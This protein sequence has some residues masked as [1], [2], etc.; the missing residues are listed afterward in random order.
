MGFFARGNPWPPVQAVL[1]DV[2]LAHPALFAGLSAAG[3]TAAAVLLFVQLTTRLGGAVSAA[4]GISYALASGWINVGYAL[5]P[6][7]FAL[8]G[9]LFLAVGASLPVAPGYRLR[10]VFV[11]LGAA[12]LALAVRWIGALPALPWTAAAVALLACGMHQHPPLTG[13][14]QQPRAV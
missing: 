5:H 2:V 13:T 10:S 9:I 6:G 1:T 11:V 14:P 4:V 3:E 8:L 12:G 7:S